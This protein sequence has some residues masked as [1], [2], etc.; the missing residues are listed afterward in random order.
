[1]AGNTFARA[2]RVA[3]G[4][5]LPP[6]LA[7]A[8]LWIS[9]SLSLGQL[10]P[11]PIKDC[12]DNLPWI[13]AFTV[14][15]SALSII[16]FE[17]MLARKLFHGKTT[18]L[19]FTLLLGL[20][21]GGVIAGSI[22]VIHGQSNIKE[23]LL[24]YLPLG[25][26]VGFLMGLVYLIIGHMR[27]TRIGIEDHNRRMVLCFI[28]ATVKSEALAGNWI[29]LSIGGL[30]VIGGTL[31]VLRSWRRMCD[32]QPVRGKVVGLENYGAVDSTKSDRYYY[33]A[34]VEYTDEFGRRKRLIDQQS[35]SPPLYQVGTEVRA[36]CNPA[37]PATGVVCS[38][39]SL[40]MAPCF[41]L[42]FGVL[43]LLAGLIQ[44]PA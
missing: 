13:F 31:L 22:T 23:L 44:S 5:V 21:S 36:L 15:P 41:L 7:M 34:I 32:W 2:L 42:G 4:L 35:A 38:F 14:I 8:T 6:L 28:S 18:M 1:M 30:C 9:V 39:K 3:C 25:A 17:L 24:G 27:L 29:P 43:F 26:C 10:V 33:A 37:Q 12:R 16:A 11:I 40:W 20:L 19:L